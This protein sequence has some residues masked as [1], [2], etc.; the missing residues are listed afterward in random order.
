MN[1]DSIGVA[2][3]GYL[4]TRDEFRYARLWVGSVGALRSFISVFSIVGFRDGSYFYYV[5]GLFRVEGELW[6]FFFDG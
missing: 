3:L 6:S 4:V 5:F 2:A 1:I